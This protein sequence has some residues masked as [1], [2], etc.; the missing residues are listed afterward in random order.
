MKRLTTFEASFS[1]D[2][3]KREQWFL[4]MEIASRGEKKQELVELIKGYCTY[5]GHKQCCAVDLERWLPAVQG[6]AGMSEL[7][8]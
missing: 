5:I 4:K 1:G 6:Y 8:E 2:C 7:E 3:S